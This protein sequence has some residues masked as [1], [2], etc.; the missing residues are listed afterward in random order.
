[1]GII[2]QKLIL[3]GMSC[4]HCVSSLEKELDKLLLLYRQVSVNSLYVEYLTDETTKSQ[5]EK[6]IKDAGCEV[7]KFENVNENILTAI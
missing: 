2:K 6:A 4:S 1:M 3:S 5:I 7:V